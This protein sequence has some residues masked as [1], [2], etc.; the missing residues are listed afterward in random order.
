[1]EIADF[2][3]CNVLDHRREKIWKDVHTIR[4]NKILGIH[5]S[6]LPVIN[7]PLMDEYFPQSIAAGNIL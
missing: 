1:M 4:Y 2:I 5:I 6:S 3:N 7:S